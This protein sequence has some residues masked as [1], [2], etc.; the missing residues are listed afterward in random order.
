MEYLRI[1]NLGELEFLAL[2]LV[3]ASVKGESMIGK[4]GTGNKY[5]LAALIRLGLKPIIYSGTRLIEL[6][7]IKKDFRD[8]SF[9]VITVGGQETSLTTEMGK[10]HWELRHAIREFWSNALDEGGATYEITKTIRGE[11]GKTFVYIPANDEVL[12][13]VSE[14]HKYF[15]PIGASTLVSYDKV[16]IFDPSQTGKTTAIYRRGVWCVEEYRQNMLFSYDIKDID[17]PETRLTSM[18]NAGWQVAMPLTKLKD[19]RAIRRLFGAVRDD[20][21]F[22]WDALGNH[23]GFK[24][25]EDSAIMK[26]FNGLWK[27]VSTKHELKYF[28]QHLL[29]SVL[30]CSDQAFK[31]LIGW[32]CK[33]I[34]HAVNRDIQW[35]EMAWPPGLKEQVNA[36]VA[37][38]KRN[39]FDWRWPI[40]FVEL[41]EPKSAIALADLRAGVCLLT[42]DAASAHPSMILKALIEEWTHLEHGVADHTVEQQHVYLDAIVSLLR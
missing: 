2:T 34:M 16:K 39:G 21:S 22:E 38:L 24:I 36:A 19:E 32:G 9:E 35:S 20:N 25:P 40:K 3:G 17:L 37:R 23:A 5:G 7:T 26:Y 8:K 18:W 28:P 10:T 14:W 42:A 6:G 11:A 33:N 4:Y 27:Y 29:P 15:T 31:V 1:G 30:V 13:M 12:D 41:A